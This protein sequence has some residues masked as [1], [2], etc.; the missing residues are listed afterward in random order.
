MAFQYASQKSAVIAW[1]TP[2]TET[3]RTGPQLRIPLPHSVVLPMRGKGI[4]PAVGSEFQ[5]A[6]RSQNLALGFQREFGSQAARSCIRDAELLPDPVDP[7]PGRNSFR[8]RAVQFG[9][10]SAVRRSE[11]R[12]G[13]DHALTCR[14]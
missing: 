4:G 5:A 9:S 11:L 7:Q 13:C 14:E 6:T 12:P 1:L 8:P 3:S 10:R 2:T